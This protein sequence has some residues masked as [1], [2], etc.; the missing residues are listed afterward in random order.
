MLGSQ[1]SRILLWRDPVDMRK[2]F[3]GLIGL[4]SNALEQD[5]LSGTLFMFV[6]RRRNYAKGIFWDRTGYVLVAKKLERGRF[7]FPLEDSLQELTR[8][9]FLLFFDG[10]VL[11]VR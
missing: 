3:S 6:N 1:I 5:S 10:I 2:S 4:V 9:K 8:Q 7:T 11:G